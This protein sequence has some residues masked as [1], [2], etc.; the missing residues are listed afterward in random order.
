ML[1]SNITFEKLWNLVEDMTIQE[2]QK[3][4]EKL[5]YVLDIEKN[6]AEKS[7]HCDLLTS[8]LLKEIKTKHSMTKK[9]RK[10]V[11]IKGK[12]LSETIIEERR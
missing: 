6:I 12:P 9:Y 8:G 2:Q 3:L 10:L 11:E 7:F 4:R 1:I 5:N